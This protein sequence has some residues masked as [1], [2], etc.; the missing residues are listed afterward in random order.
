MNL[1]SIFLNNR[2]VQDTTVDL[3]VNQMV[4]AEVIK[5]QIRALIPGQTIM[6]EIVGKNGSDVQIRLLDELLVNA[7]LDQD[8]NVGIGKNMAFQVKN[9]GSVLTL[10]PLYENLATDANA[11][12]ALDMAGIPLTDKTLEMAG[13][14]M[15]NGLP[16]DKNS[17]QQVYR[18]MSLYPDTQV[19]DLVNL[20]KLGIPVNESNLAQ[21]SAYQNMNHQLLEGMNQVL[22]DLPQML[23][24]MISE[25][26][27][28]DASALLKVLIGMASGERLS[29]Q[30]ATEGMPSQGNI[31]GV[32][33]EGMPTQGTGVEVQLS[34]GQ[35]GQTVQT[36]QTGAVFTD[37]PVNENLRNDENN[38]QALQQA[39]E[40]GQH[41][42]TTAGENI[43]WDARGIT[44]L[45]QRAGESQENIQRL[46]S[47]LDQM[48]HAGEPQSSQRGEEAF[49]RALLDNIKEKWLLTPQEME[50]PGKVQEFYKNL[51]E[52]LQQLTESLEQVGQQ[53]SNVFKAANNMNQNLD[54]LQQLNQM[55]TYVQLPVKLQHSEAHGDLYV[56]TNKRHLAS[57]DGQISA[58]LHLDMEH[59]G[60]V[61]VYVALQ[62]ERLNT[63]FYLRDD[64]M[65]DFINEHMDILTE[66]LQKK[67][68]HCSYELTVRDQ[69]KNEETANIDSLIQHEPKI[70]MVKYAFDV[71]G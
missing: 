53:Q 37:L 43:S 20:H 48:G 26:N 8:M 42:Q 7:K 31:N 50:E 17:L 24:G 38:G 22:S 58:L 41:A 57:K 49:L 66:R 69:E 70:P 34:A 59:L 3:N 64:E 14:M 30:G 27:Y 45:L 68:F 28:S 62:N 46:L 16:I 9:N 5:R 21:Y 54:F 6:G 12:K 11:M 67:G 55:Y 18:E 60:P 36:Q 44:E 4:T 47:Q 65:L 23:S 39:G 15:D 71:R 13:K 1:S 10:S 63:N 35:E 61:D 29:A 33:T 52:Q 25:G 2:P 51:S 32:P 56:Y 40:S 19:G